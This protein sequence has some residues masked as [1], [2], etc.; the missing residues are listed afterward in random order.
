VSTTSSGMMARTPVELGSLISAT[1]SDRL[2]LAW[3]V[4]KHGFQK[5]ESHKDFSSQRMMACKG[6]YGIATPFDSI[7]DGLLHFL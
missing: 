6:S 1:G 7:V 4:K 5:S 2:R 3:L